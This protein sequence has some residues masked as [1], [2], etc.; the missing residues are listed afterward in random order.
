LESRVRAAE[1]ALRN[2]ALAQPNA[3]ALLE[4]GLDRLAV[5]LEAEVGVALVGEGLSDAFV[6]CAS[7]PP[8]QPSA[9]LEVDARDE[10]ALLESAPAVLEVGPLVSKLARA[11]ALVVPLEGSVPGAFVLG[12]DTTW[13]AAERGAA[14][15]LG[16]LFGILWAWSE[17][18]SRFQRTVD[19][20]DDALF[21]VGHDE[22]GRRSYAFVSPQIEALTGLDLDALLAG[23][24]DWTELIADE[25]AVAFR[26]HDER[27]QAGEASRIEVRVWVD[28]EVVWLSERATPSV[29]AAGRPV[30][31]GLLSDVTAQKEAEAQLDLARRVAERAAQTRMAFLRMMSHELRTPLGAIRGFADILVEETSALEDAPPEI[32]EFAGTIRDASDRALRLVTDLLDLSRLETGAIDLV[33]QPVDLGAIVS[34]VAARHKDAATADLEVVLPADPVS[35]KADPVRVDQVVDQLVSNAVRFT[36]SGRIEVALSIGSAGLSALEDEGSTARAVLEVADTGV[37]IADDA[38]EAVFEP[39]VQEDSRVNRE[40]GGT[41]LGLAI[42]LRLARQMGGDLEVESVKGQG[43]TF[44]LTLPVG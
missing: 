40:Y 19:D 33:T 30:A 43:S 28:G 11:T 39:F 8:S 44:R 23:D 14:G 26:A 17:A 15:R 18:E 34:A 42:A 13:T 3:L 22:H 1:A 24:A 35:V 25:D 4:G 38:L 27:L 31:G 41:G 37:G 9:L 2:D 21:T 20:L 29:D 16:T 7:W 10:R 5:A 32:P 36:P 12:R 6:R